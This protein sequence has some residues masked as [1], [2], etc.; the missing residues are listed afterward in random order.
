MSVGTIIEILRGRL[1]STG[2]LSTVCGSRMHGSLLSQGVR[3]L[4]TVTAFGA[5]QAHHP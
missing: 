5:P 3:C 1:Y 2:P 4:A